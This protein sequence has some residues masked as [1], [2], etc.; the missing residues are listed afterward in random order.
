MAL[1][2]QQAFAQH[3]LSQIAGLAN[4]FAPKKADPKNEFLEKVRKIYMKKLEIKIRLAMGIGGLAL[5]ILDPILAFQIFRL[6]SWIGAPSPIR[7]I[8]GALVGI[9]VLI[10]SITSFIMSLDGDAAKRWARE[11][12]L[13]SESK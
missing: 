3:Q 11:W 10:I 9:A 6:W 7:E 12:V 1:T 2:P 5:F 4:A 8:G 13:D